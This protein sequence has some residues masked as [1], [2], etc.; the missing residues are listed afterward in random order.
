MR[1]DRAFISGPVLI[2]RAEGK[3]H[4]NPYPSGSIQSSGIAFPTIPLIHSAAFRFGRGDEGNYVLKRIKADWGLVKVAGKL[5]LD[6]AANLSGDLELKRA[7]LAQLIGARLSGDQ[8]LQG[9][10]EGR[11]WINADLRRETFEASGWLTGYHVRLRNLSVQ[12]DPVIL[13]Y[14]PRLQ[15]VTFRKIHVGKWRLQGRNCRLDSVD[16]E[17]TPLSVRGGGKVSFAS[18]PVEK[19]KDWQGSMYLNMVGRLDEDYYQSL[20]LLVREGISRDSLGSPSFAFKVKGNLQRQTLVLDEIYG[21][22]FKSIT[23]KIGGR[24]KRLF[25]GN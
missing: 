19:S 2:V 23:R 24:L 17:G 25:S 9:Q 8:S 14:M 16:A 6:T 11:G 13:K 4:W 18:T 21:K 12:K 15:D 20:D 1:I 10:V 22:A 3:I 5:S 7:D